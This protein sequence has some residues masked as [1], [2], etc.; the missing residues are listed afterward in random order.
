[1]KRLSGLFA[2]AAVLGALF[3]PTGTAE[4]SST[5]PLAGL[6]AICLEQGGLWYPYPVEG[7]G[8]VV[9]Y[10]VG[11]I[12]RSQTQLTYLGSLCN[13]AGYSGFAFFGIGIPVPGIYVETWACL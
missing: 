12:V 9:C 4:P 7:V 8:Q 11:I 10:D 2:V 3:I 5:G 1:M 6:E 13:A